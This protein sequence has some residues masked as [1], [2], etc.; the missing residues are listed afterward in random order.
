MQ[1]LD[2][3]APRQIATMVTYCNCVDRY[4]TKYHH[5]D[6]GLDHYLAI[7][8]A[9]SNRWTGIWNG[10]MEWNMEWNDGMENGMEQ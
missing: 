10:M 9:V 6:C 1:S 3:L 8:G 4:I 5:K 7:S 2:S